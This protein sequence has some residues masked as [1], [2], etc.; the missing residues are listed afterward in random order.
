MWA[1]GPWTI[2]AFHYHQKAL[3]SVSVKESISGYDKVCFKTAFP[4]CILQY[5]CCSA[6]LWALTPFKQYIHVVPT[7]LSRLLWETVLKESTL[8]LLVLA[9]KFQMKRMKCFLWIHNQFPS[10]FF[11]VTTAYSNQEQQQFHGISSAVSAKNQNYG[12]NVSMN[13]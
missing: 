3:Y 9:R 11:S 7:V 4:L 1:H 10:L 13:T 8:S 5:F 6:L 12:N 2:W